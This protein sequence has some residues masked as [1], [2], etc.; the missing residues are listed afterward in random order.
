MLAFAVRNMHIA[1]RKEPA[2]QNVPQYSPQALFEALSNAV[3]QRDYSIRG[4]RFR[5]AMFKGRL[6]I[7]SPGSLPH[8]LT[9]ESLEE[10]QSTR[11]WLLASVLGR[12]NVGTSRGGEKTVL[13]G[14]ARRRYPIMRCA[15]RE[16]S[17]SLP[18]FRLWDESES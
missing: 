10:R 13:Q 9:I 6:E 12:M 11:Y 16:L 14:A 1:A 18:V 4:S 17:G 2:R 5:L 15:T 8:N 3:V 7:C